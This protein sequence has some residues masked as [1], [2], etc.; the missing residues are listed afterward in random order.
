MISGQKNYNRICVIGLGYIGLPTASFLATK[1]YQILGVEVNRDIVHKL[2]KGQVILQE[3]SLDMLVKSAVNSGHL[4]AAMEPEKADIFII[5]VPTP[6]YKD[7]HPDLSY[8]KQACL[9]ISAYLEAGNLVILE[10]TCPVGTTESMGFW[11]SESRPELCVASKGNGSTLCNEQ[12]NIAHCPERVLPGQILREMVENDRLVGGIDK[13]STSCAAGFYRDFVQGKVYETDSRIAELAKLTENAYRDVNIAFANELSIICEHLQINVWE[14]VRL[15]NK[16]PRVNILNPG[17]GVGGHCIA[18]DPWFIIHS[19]PEK[20]KLMQT[21]REVNDSKPQYILDKVL[22]K[23]DRFKK[24]KIGCFGLAFK[25][26]V[27]DLRESPALNIVRNLAAKN[28]GE[29]LVVEPYINQLPEE[30]GFNE[31]ISLVTRDQALSQGDILILLVDHDYFKDI[32]QVK[33]KEKIVID[34]KGIWS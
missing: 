17:P 12:I 29:L 18:V 10:S 32:E 24:P 9:T 8:V 5:A 22:K 21:A 20:T 14:L 7:H 33:L 4:K 13:V 28:A 19:V 2:N 11:I 27:D 30:L 34:T 16:H 3:P 6:F 1:G 31:A 23:A 26:N 15:A 25:A